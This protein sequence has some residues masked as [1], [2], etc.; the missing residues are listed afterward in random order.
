MEE[1]LDNQAVETVPAKIKKPRVVRHWWTHKDVNGG[2]ESF[3]SGLNIYKIIWIFVIGSFIGVVFE[4]A[5]VFFMTGELMRRSGMMYGPFN[6]IYGM[7]AVLFSVLLYRFRKKNALII[8]FVSGVIGMAFEF[9]CSYVQ[10]FLFGSVSWEYSDMATNIGGRTNL[11]Y[12]FG[13]GIMGLIFL[14]HTW[15]FLSEMIERIPNKVG[16][17]LSVIVTVFM[18]FNLS[19]SA[20]AVYRYNMRNQQK[21]ATNVVTRWLDYTYPDSVMQEKYP[22][23]EFKQIDG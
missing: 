15:P 3:A 7:G 1:F 16:K 22:S 14:T 2:E 5:Y 23:M 8:F 9:V 19:V 4:T 17:P 6:Q 11:F 21:P 12:G 20:A 18:V 13:W 10:E